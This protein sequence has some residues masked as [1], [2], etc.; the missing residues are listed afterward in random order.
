MCRLFGLHANKLVDVW[1]SFYETPKKSLV[2]SSHENPDGWGVAWLDDKDWHV[3]KEPIPLYYSTTA[4]EIIR[5]YVRGR[6]VVSHVRFASV[7][8]N[9]IE[10]THPWLYRGWVFAHNGTIRNKQMLLKLLREEYRDLEGDTDSEIFFHLLIQEIEDLEDSIEGIMNVIEKIVGKGIKFSSLNFIASDGENLYALRYATERLNYYS[11]YY[12]KRPKE[13][14]EL[15]RLSRETKQL[16]SMKLARG[17]RAV[18]VASEIMSDEKYWRRV[19]NKHLVIVDKNLNI[20]L[21]PIE[22]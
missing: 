15:R 5:K 21:E 4:R 17:E 11:L 19:P 12:I 14:L 6:I 13:G 22:V 1:Y 9:K 2:E 10:N 18:I 7:G 16:I 20:E 8:D 3:H